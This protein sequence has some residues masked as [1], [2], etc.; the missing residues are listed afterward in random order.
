M[1][2]VEQRQFDFNGDYSRVFWDLATKERPGGHGEGG[3][4]DR[5]RAGAAACADDHAARAAT[6]RPAPTTSTRRVRLTSVSTYF[7]K[8]DEQATFRLTYDV[9]DAAQR[10]Q[11]TAE[12]YWQ[13]IGAQWAVPGPTSPSPS[14]RRSR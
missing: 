9:A 5:G 3:R 10:Y 7:R 14:G 8:A 13:F 2:V 6:D 4:G 1:S 11:D 12:L